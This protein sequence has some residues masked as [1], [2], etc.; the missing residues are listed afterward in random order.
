MISLRTDYQLLRPKHLSAARRGD[1]GQ[2]L[3]ASVRSFAYSNH[4]TRITRLSFLL[5]G[6]PSGSYFHAGPVGLFV[7][8]AFAPRAPGRG[9]ISSGRTIALLDPK[10]FWNAGAG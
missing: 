9:C 1:L 8:F 5:A 7:F 2:S 10:M 4:I 6:P 3:G